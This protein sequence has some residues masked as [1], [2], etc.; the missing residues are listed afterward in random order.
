MPEAGVD[1]LTVTRVVHASVLLQ[2]GG[3]SLLTDPWYSEKRGY[4][5]GEPVGVP[6]AALPPLAA[7]LCSQGDYSHCDWNGFQPYPDHDLPVVVNRGSGKRAR[8]AGF[9]NVIELDPWQAARL[10]PM[11]IVATPAA[12]GVLENSY[13]VECGGR[14]VFFG[15]HSPL[16]AGMDSEMLEVAHRFPSLDLALLPISGTQIRPLFY[17]QIVMNTR[18]AAALAAQ[19]RPR[20][21]VPI[22]YRFT[23]GRLRDRFLLK[24]PGT[25]EAFASAMAA[26]A[27]Q[28]QLRVLEPGAALVID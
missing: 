3:C 13:I 4:Y 9:A 2:F 11:R 24:Y 23:A 26:T 1:V 18:Q 22:H 14:S 16:G 15:A 6:L 20:Y 8:K 25:L 28:A 21:V 19:L 7:V 12:H 27:P 10:G 17:Q 5:H